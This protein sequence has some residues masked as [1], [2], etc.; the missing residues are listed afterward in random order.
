MR[1][2]VKH[3][4]IE[5][6]RCLKCIMMSNYTQCSSAISGGLEE[7]KHVRNFAIVM[8]ELRQFSSGNSHAYSG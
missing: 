4:C 2:R 8:M 7:I 6:A 5:C 1:A 3:E